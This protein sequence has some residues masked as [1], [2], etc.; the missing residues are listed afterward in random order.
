VIVRTLTEIEG[1]DRDVEASTWR[2]RR[3]LLARD[4]QPFS[5]HDT[6]LAARTE[7]TMWYANHVEAV[8]CIDGEGELVNDETGETHPLRTG[9]LYL[10]DGHEH[11]RVRAD[12]D[13]RTVCVFTPPV[14]GQETHDADGAYPLIAEAVTAADTTA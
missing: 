13:V 5:M 2:S 12:T 9:T 6:V 14:T 7:T 11:H 8:Y 3:L 4:G 1:T 10:L